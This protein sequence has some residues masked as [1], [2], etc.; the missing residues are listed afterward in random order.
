[1]QTGSQYTALKL[2]SVNC[3][4][5]QHTLNALSPRPLTEVVQI[6]ETIDYITQHYSILH[7]QTHLK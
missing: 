2:R 7:T 3:K 6:V 1:M 5:Q 4:K